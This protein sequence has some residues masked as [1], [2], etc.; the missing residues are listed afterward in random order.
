LVSNNFG[1][2]D[3]FIKEDEFALNEEKKDD[4]QLKKSFPR[5]VTPKSFASLLERKTRRNESPLSLDFNFEELPSMRESKTKSCAFCCNPE[6]VLIV[7]DNPFNLLSLKTQV[8][9]FGLKVET[10]VNG[11]EALEKVKRAHENRCGDE[12]RLYRV[13]L[14]DLDMPVMDGFQST[15]EIREFLGGQQYQGRI[16]IAACTANVVQ[17]SKRQYFDEYICK[18]VLREHLSAIF[19]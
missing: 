13:V 19:S 17:D 6:T 4:S 7:D 11:L 5:E 10:A 9:S 3:E 2:E 8:L 12:C 1:E 15:K 14:M 18:P 16:I